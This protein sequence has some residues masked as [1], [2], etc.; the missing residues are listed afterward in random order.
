MSSLWDELETRQGELK[1]KTEKEGLNH[2]KKRES[3]REKKLRQTIQQQTTEERRSE[4]RELFS[5]F[6]GTYAFLAFFN[7]RK[8]ILRLREDM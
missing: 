5:S 4:I 8:I 7:L 6:T 1:K 3:E 2:Q